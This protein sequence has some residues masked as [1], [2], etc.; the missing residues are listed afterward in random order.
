MEV[1]KAL[2]FRKKVQTVP[3]PIIVR[4][5]GASFA[6]CSVKNQLNDL[7]L[8]GD[9]RGTA[10]D[11]RQC[12]RSE[13]SCSAFGPLTNGNRSWA[14]VWTQICLDLWASLLNYAYSG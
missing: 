7:E 3:I 14:G 8:S 10:N 1:G 11:A 9:L 12:E 2:G 5:Q 6:L 13:R 4:D